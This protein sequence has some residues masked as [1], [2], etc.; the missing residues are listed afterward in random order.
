MLRLKN[1]DGQDIGPRAPA[2]SQS[3]SKLRAVLSE[4]HRHGVSYCYWKSTRRIHAALNG[5]SDLD[6]LVG[7]LDQHRVEMLLLAQDFKLF[8]AQAYRDHPSV[9]SFLG[10]DEVS[11]R[12]VHI[13]LHF[14]LIVGKRL[15]RN[16]RLPWE[17]I[18]LGR[19]L[20]HPVFEVRVLEPTIEAVLLAVRSCV[21]LRRSDPVALRKWQATKGK[22][23]LDRAD[24]AAR[25]RAAELRN[26]ATVLL[27]ERLASMLV[28]AIYSER[29]LED[30]R[31]FRRCAARYLSAFRTYNTWEAVLRG[32]WRTLWWA[33]GN[34]NRH[35]FQLPR[36]G[37]R[38]AP[39][40]G[41]VVAIVGVDGSGKTTVNA[42][43]RAWLG[44]EVDVV[45]IYFGTGDG[46]PSLLLKLFKLM[47]PLVKCIL[48]AKPKGASHGKVSGRPPSLLYG[49][50][51]TVWAII[52]AREKRSKL[53]AARRGA[54]RGVVI[55]T[56][57]YPQN[58][59]ASF[60]DGPLLTRLTWIPRWLRNREAA[61]Y[62][63]AQRLKPDLVVELEV[64]AETAARREA[65]MDPAVIRER[66]TDLR[67]LTFA[68]APIVRIN[69]EQP[70]FDVIRAVKR[71]IWRSL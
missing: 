67:R 35:L 19:A 44:S 49:L 34:M 50:L 7:R 71:E 45:P 61:A 64:L 55:I 54:E 1:L 25:V 57:R 59:I 26:L 2:D 4:F 70:L 51:L 52:V 36:P 16:Y 42:A 17:E 32:S 30:Q 23:A 46:K 6:L 29:E 60:N 43:I 47:L 31:R 33:A 10:Y 8:P 20:L 12:I 22:F 5:E 66:V 38:R 3:L 65:E 27:N 39:G 56:D 41:C 9:S 15:L 62:A 21:E 18:V 37:C 63:L 69:A 48:T 24:V 13:H 53:L 14:R 58:E 11:G 40:G 28:E 68:G